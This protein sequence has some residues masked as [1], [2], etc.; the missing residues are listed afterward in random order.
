MPAIDH[1]LALGDKCSEL[2]NGDD[3][4]DGATAGGCLLRILITDG[5]TSQP[6]CVL[7]PLPI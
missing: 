2:P 3:Y 4:S 1:P 6:D 7:P 5:Q